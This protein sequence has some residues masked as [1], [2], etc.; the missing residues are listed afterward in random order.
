MIVLLGVSLAC[1]K[2]YTFTLNDPARAGSAELKPGEYGLKLDGSQVVL[3]DRT[4]RRIETA[5]RIE[6][7]N[8]KFDG[9]VM[10]ISKAD[11]TNRIHWVGL[12]GSKKKVVFE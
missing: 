9:M 7:T 12:K 4:G 5:V 8:R 10:N 1:A 6:D 11:G 3:M 2:T